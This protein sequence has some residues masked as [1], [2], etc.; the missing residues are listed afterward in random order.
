MVHV[1]QSVSEEMRDLPSTHEGPRD[2]DP[3]LESGVD[4]SHTPP[5]NSAGRQFGVLMFIDVY[6]LLLPIPRSSFLQDLAGLDHAAMIRY[7]K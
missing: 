6:L 3:C 4:K 1:L 5:P 7:H 2:D